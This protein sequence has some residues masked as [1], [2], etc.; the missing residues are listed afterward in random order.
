MILGHLKTYRDL[1]GIILLWVL[2]GATL[3]KLVVVGVVVVSYLLILRTRD[4]SKIFFS[5]LT[6]L[7]FSDSRSRVFAFA[8]TAKIGIVLL[9]VCFIIINWKEF[10]NVPNKV[11]TFFLP[12]LF[13]AV[14]ASIWSENN[15]VSIQ[16]S[17]S[18]SIVLFI[19]PLLF[20]RSND[21]NSSFK[22]DLI[23]YFFLVLT[24]GLLVHLVLPNFTSLEG[25]YR[26]LLG[27]PNGL[28]IFQT[29]MFP[30]V[31]LI[32]NKIGK[33]FEEN[34]FQ[35]MFYLVFFLLR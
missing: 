27:N 10:K 30:V 8:E 9:L 35:Y 3:P 19:V 29:V 11:F 12:F 31:Y 22:K 18:Y 5:F 17:L 1:Y 14:T 23:V 24:V 34:G 21:E 33:A 15:L 7:I 25:R 13:F 32:R 26:G 16:K 2:L 20:M 6:I 28:G 4:L